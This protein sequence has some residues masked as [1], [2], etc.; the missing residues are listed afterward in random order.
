MI[1]RD[2]KYMFTILPYTYDCINEM[3]DQMVPNKH[4]AVFDWQ[5]N[6][7]LWGLCGLTRKP[8]LRSVIY[9][10]QYRRNYLDVLPF[11]TDS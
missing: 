10:I 9:M 2:T 6:R 8:R 5:S 7:E 11:I 1:L 4:N 3:D